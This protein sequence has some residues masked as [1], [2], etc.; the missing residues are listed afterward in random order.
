[1]MRSA[2]ARLQQRRHQLRR[3]RHARLILAILP[4]VAVIGQ[5]RGHALGRSTLQRVHRQQQFHQM[6]FDGR[7]GRLHHKA[8]GAAHVFENLQMDLAVGKLPHAHI[9]ELEARDGRRFLP[10]A[11][12]LALPVKI[13]IRSG[14]IARA[15]F[16][17]AICR[18]LRPAVLN[19]RAPPCAL[20]LARGS[21]MTPETPVRP[22]PPASPSPDAPAPVC[23]DYRKSRRLPTP[24]RHGRHVS[25]RRAVIVSPNPVQLRIP[26]QHNVLKIVDLVWTYLSEHPPQTPRWK[27]FS[28]FCN[29][30]FVNVAD[31][32]R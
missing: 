17:A 15:G 2:P 9:A 21:R 4:A 1:M 13:L 23:P 8:I 29:A 12:G 19:E 7:A 31:R 32:S 30:T 14:F 6:E 25:P 16:G 22:E 18:Y 10:P 5:H 27:L 11:T 3:N 24:T 20:I 26:G 28:L